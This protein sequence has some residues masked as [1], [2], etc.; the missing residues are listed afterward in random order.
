MKVAV[1]VVCF[2]LLA[3]CASEH[4]AM[5]L[6][7]SSQPATEVTLGV[8]VAAQT[9]AGPAT[10]SA[11]PASTNPSGF[12]AEGYLQP[13]DP[14]EV[15]IRPKAYGG[16]L[17]I[18]SIAAN[19]AQVKQ[20]DVILQLDPEPLNR[21]LAAA[22]NALL[23]AQAN[24]D[25]SDAAAKLSEQSAALTLRQQQDETRA[26]DEGVKWWE[27]VDGPQILLENDLLLKESN[28]MVGDQQDELDQLKKM[29]KSE[30][31]T[32]ATADIV[33]K[34]ALR[35]LEIG[36]AR[37][38]MTEA[39]VNKSKTFEYPIAKQ[40]P[41]DAQTTA[42]IA[43][44]QLQLAQAQEVIVRKTELAAVHV[45]LD[46]ANRKV[47][48]LTGDLENL[49]VH[50]PS[51]GVVAYG[52]FSGGIFQADPKSLRVGE[53]VAAKQVLM[54]LYVPGKLAVHLD[55]PEAKFVKLRAGQSVTV[56]SD[57]F[58][59]VKLHG[60]CDSSMRFPSSQSNGPAYT[61]IISLHD[62]DPRLSPGSRVKIHADLPH[63]DETAAAIKQ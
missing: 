10:S 55:L 43:L 9:S 56:Q 42:H 37:L 32:N 18:V 5:P 53:D 50:A 11:G 61:Q 4:A 2:S 27:T 44:Q 47:G 17:T 22:K 59:D 48:E 13:V 31:L 20:G 58:P 62:V 33:V 8:A 7:A 60:D 35:S 21:Q 38:S 52:A 3:S 14:F 1:G 23:V 63:G 15:R 34:R 16:E 57:A 36:K 46:E 30:E 29:Y 51:E 6:V 39:R 28:A 40:R 25:R 19:G 24:V 54:T 49:T 45:A 26:A 41:L 12:E